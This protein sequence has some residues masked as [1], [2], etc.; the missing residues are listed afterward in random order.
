[1]TFSLL[2][3]EAHEDQSFIAQ[4]QDVTPRTPKRQRS[5]KSDA[6]RRWD[7]GLE[8]RGQHQIRG[9]HYIQRIFGLFPRD[10]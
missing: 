6:V 10:A 4:F 7:H 9:Q 3:D 8:A 2:R 1:M 5:P